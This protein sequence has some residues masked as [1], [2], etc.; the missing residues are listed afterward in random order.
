MYDEILHAINDD[1]EDEDEAVLA[2][3][4]DA[5]FEASDIRG[6]DDG[7]WPAWPEQEMLEWV[8]NDIQAR[9]G[10][11]VESVINGP[12][13]E[14]LSARTAEIVAAFEAHGYQCREDLRLIQRACGW[15]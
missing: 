4:A 3:T 1:E 15:G 5:P 6:Y 10:R 2:Y 14:L 9:Y 12:Y 13:L 11:E 7:D 8:P